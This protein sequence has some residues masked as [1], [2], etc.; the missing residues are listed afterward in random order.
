MTVDVVYLII[1]PMEIPLSRQSLSRLLIQIILLAVIAGILYS[2]MPPSAWPW[3]GERLSTFATVF[4]GIFI[5]ALPFL[6]MGTLASGLVEVFVSDDWLTR[7]TPR[8]ALPAAFSG[9]LLGLIFPIC[10]CGTV[11]LDAP[12]LSQRTAAFRRSCLPSGRAGFKSNRDLQH[13]H[14]IR[15]GTYVVLEAGSQ[16]VDRSFSRA[17][18][19]GVEGCER[20]HAIIQIRS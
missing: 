3:L 12:T 5:E 2:S 6:L 10:E 9:A 4:L 20:Y 19:F 16:F 1:L 14:G 11:P 7:V 18:I 8:R 15:L 13:C 17:G